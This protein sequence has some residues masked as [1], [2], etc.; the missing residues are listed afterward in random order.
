MRDDAL[1]EIIETSGFPLQGLVASV[2]PDAS[3]P[4]VRLDEVE[5]LGAITVLADGKTWPHL[6]AH[7][8]RCTRSDG[9]VKQPSPSTYPEMYAESNSRLNQGPASDRV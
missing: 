9:K 7:A 4:E 8:Q 5:D 1:E 2:R 3:A 6:P